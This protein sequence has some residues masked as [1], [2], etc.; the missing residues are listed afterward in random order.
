MPNLE[1]NI[2]PEDGIRKLRE[3]MEA[4]RAT[5]WGDLLDFSDTKS[6]EENTSE[7]VS[8]IL[9]SGPAELRIQ[10]GSP[11]RER[12]PF[13]WR[14]EHEIKRKQL[15]ENKSIIQEYVTNSS[16]NHFISYIY[17]R[18]SSVWDDSATWKTYLKFKNKTTGEIFRWNGT[19]AV[20]SKFWY[21]HNRIAI[22]KWI[23][24]NWKLYY[25]KDHTFI[26]IMSDDTGNPLIS[27]QK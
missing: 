7:A 25:S 5:K 18:E 8:N 22:Q 19:Y 24:K 9:E 13:S 15:S 26:D 16:G 11:I 12:I 23:I 20:I 4:R 14:F 17:L 1:W 6:N 3:K 2:P 27:E 21:T 10:D